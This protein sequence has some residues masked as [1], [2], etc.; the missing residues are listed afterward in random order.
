MPLWRA[1][2]QANNSPKFAPMLLQKAVTTANIN[3]AFSN[4]T[5]NIFGRFTAGVFGIDTNQ[6]RAARAAVGVPRP[7][8]AGWN[9]RKVGTGGRAGRVTYETL[10][11]GKSIGKPGFENTTHKQMALVIN[12][13]PRNNTAA[14]NTPISIYMTAQT[15][16]PGG[17]ITYN[18]QRDQGNGTWVAVTDGGIYSGSNT[19]NLQIANNFTANLQA[20]RVILQNVNTNNVTSTNAFVRVV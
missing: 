19:N 8:H 18:W 6:Q 10:V 2:D 7:Q 12:Q 1:Q 11:A 15:V 16:P 14:N 9:L 5:S 20:Y 4:T 3:L 13:Q 17:V